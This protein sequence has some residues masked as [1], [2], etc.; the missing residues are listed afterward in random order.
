MADNDYIPT[1]WVRNEP[2]P[3]ATNTHVFRA[4]RTGYLGTWSEWATPTL[5]AEYSA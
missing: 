4:E 1:G 2:A 5:V 3:D